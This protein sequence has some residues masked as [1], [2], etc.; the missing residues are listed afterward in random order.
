MMTRPRFTLFLAVPTL[1]ALLGPI[2]AAQAPAQTPAQTLDARIEKE[3]PSLV[4]TYKALHAAPEL[5]FQEKNTSALLARELRA[6]GY[7]VTENFGK[8][9]VPGRT[10]YGVV[11]VMKNGAGPR[12]LI[13]TDMDALPV[14]EK[15]GLAY[16]SKVRGKNEAGL[17][18]GVMHACGHDIHMT[19]FLGTAHV[20]AQLRSEWRGTVMLIG[21]PAEEGV[22]GAKGMV[23]GGLYARFGQPDYAI[24]LHDSSDL[25]A[26]KVG[27]TPGYALASS[28]SVD[29]Q[30]RGVGGHGSRP[31]NAKD[32]IVL[33]AQVVLALQTIVSRENSPFDPAVVTVGSIHGGT[34]HNIIPDDVRLQL[35]IRTYKE[36][37]RQRILTAIERIAR[38]AAL[39]AAVPAERMPVMTVRPDFAPATYNDPALTE[40][41]ARALERALGKENITATAPVMGSE[42]FG[43]F[44]L[45][46]RAVPISMFWLG[47]SDPARVRAHQEKGT[48]LPGLHSSEFAPLPEPTIR[49]G[50][51]AM[52]TVAL[53]LL[54]K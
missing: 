18:A 10:P 25:A 13:R 7:E 50:V 47:A 12:L 44:G 26:G 37:V 27:Y 14:E 30:I 46:Q 20:L 16:A 35:T 33:A 53:D 29:L 24:A 49:T 38:N 15:T 4:E 39:A 42:D 8:Y 6:L 9:D 51:K 31:D 48:A 32:P 28:T 54:K 23:D 41:I 45:D 21:Q 11:A 43:R 22:G 3:L 1:F 36:D 52:V 17:E 2:A 19:S 40:R 34:R 5:S